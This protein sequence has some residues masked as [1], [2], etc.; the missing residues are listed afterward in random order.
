[1]ALDRIS[2][3]LL[4]SFG[5]LVAMEPPAPRLRA[6]LAA[7]GFEVSLEQAEAAFLAEIAYYIEHHVEG[8]DHAS[9]D[10]LRD[11]C[12]RVM[13]EALDAPPELDVRSAMLAAIHFRAF[14]DA[15]PALRELRAAGLR[16]VV[17][18]N[19]DCSL[20]EV[21]REA[22]LSDLVDGVVTSAGAGAA[23]PHPRLFA[24]ALELAGSGA[25]ETVYVGDS[26]RTDVAGAHAAG[27]RAVLLKRDGDR[28]AG[29]PP[30]SAPGPEPA[31]RI[32]T[33]AE[34]PS[35]LLGR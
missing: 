12:A 8:R 30:E 15:A 24:A 4:D 25:D 14:P 34:L 7:R 6:E 10:D 20:G 31:A 22:G 35:V 1:V 21:L 32:T 29:V 2:T 13:S 11:R 16:L 9:L 5:T 18:S 3:V 23:K 27:I 19:W 33:L 28:P 26:P 17:A